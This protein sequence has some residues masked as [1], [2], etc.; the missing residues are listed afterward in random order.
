MVQKNRNFIVPLPELTRLLS[1]EHMHLIASRYPMQLEP[2][3]VMNFLIL[4]A[5]YQLI[6]SNQMVPGIVRI[7]KVHFVFQMQQMTWPMRDNYGY[8]KVNHFI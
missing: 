6:Q 8:I 3:V 7:D 2:I 5:K 4:S 1:A